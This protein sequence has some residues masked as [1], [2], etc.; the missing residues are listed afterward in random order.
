M[1]T[2]AL[3]GVDLYY[4]EQGSGPPVLLIHGNGGVAELWDEI[5]DALAPDHRVIVPDRRSFRR[6]QAEFPKDIRI[7]ADDMA[8]LL[9]NLDAAPATVVGWSAGGVIALHLAAKRPDLISSLVLLEP[10]VIA[11]RPS[12]EPRARGRHL[13]D[14]AEARQAG[15]RG[16]HVLPLGV[17]LHGRRER[18]RLVSRGAFAARCSTPRPPSS[19]RRARAGAGGEKIKAERV[20]GIALPTTILCGDRTDPAFG[21]GSR[22]VAD[23]IPGATLVP[24]PGGHMVATDA[25]QQ[26]VTAVRAA[27]AAT[28][29]RRPDAPGTRS[30]PGRNAAPESPTVCRWCR[31]ASPATLSASQT[32]GTKHEP[33]RPRSRSCRSVRAHGGK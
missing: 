1:P 26:V 22:W 3:D 15:G 11:R 2:I 19:A 24:V 9:E 7:H 33:E 27:T 10:A 31:G 13:G 28:R 30:T 21:R 4:D 17:A 29:P 20:A 6:S 8:A 16:A 5:R 25:P 14:P 23:R 18:V 32:G 12:A